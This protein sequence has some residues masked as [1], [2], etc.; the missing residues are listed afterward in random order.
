MIAMK[1][2]L[3]GNFEVGSPNKITINGRPY[4]I[5][6]ICLKKFRELISKIEKK[7]EH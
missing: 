1:C 4:D 3:C 5:C 6:E 2:D 7:E